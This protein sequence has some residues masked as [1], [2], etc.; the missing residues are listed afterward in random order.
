MHLFFNMF[1]L[2]MFGTPLELHWGS[3]AFLKYYFVTGI[4]A[5]II[6]TL[7]SYLGGGNPAIPT[8]GA[9][10]A[11]FGVLVAYAMAFP[12]SQVLFMFFIPLSARTVVAIYAIMELAMT[13][14]YHGGDGIARFAHLGV[15]LVG[16]I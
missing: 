14:Q 4:G 16:Y 6:H 3:R 7:V 9:S 15:M 11:I 12:R 2:V 8:I 1:G 10:G 13:I 5:G